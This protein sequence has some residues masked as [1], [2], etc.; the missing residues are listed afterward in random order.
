MLSS[1]GGSGRLLNFDERMKSPSLGLVMGFWGISNVLVIAWWWADISDRFLPGVLR[2]AGIAFFVCAALVP[3]VLLFKVRRSFFNP[4]VLGMLVCCC[5]ALSITAHEA[6][7]LRERLQF[8]LDHER[9]FAHVD[10]VE[11]VIRPL[12]ARITEVYVQVLGDDH[13]R[14][15]STF[16]THIV[17]NYMFDSL[18]F[19]A[20]FAL[21]TLLL[22]PTASW[23]CLLTFAFYTQ[24]AIYP[25]RMGPVFIAG[26]LFWQLFLLVSRRYP[27]AIISGLIISFGRTDVVFAS[28][29]VLLSLAAFERRWPTLKEWGLFGLLVGISIAV[30]KVLIWMHPGTDFRSFL[31][32][33]GDYFSKLVVNLLTMKLAV[34]IA[35]PV[36]AIVIVRTF[37]LTRTMAVVLPAGLI[38]VGIVFVIA[39]FSET[40][41][42]IPALTALAFVASEALG[43]LLETGALDPGVTTARDSSMADG[44]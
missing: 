22:S 7:L 13:T 20:V 43:K 42:I 33:H 14:G 38:H 4:V 37:T 11:G 1:L 19:L 16:H 3:L 18:S 39:D 15:G 41:L 31:I 27:A 30:P 25:G 36:L 44:H 34:A 29:F 35:S 12:I 8:S 32:T 28:A 23:L 40:R 26:G 5:L 9:E 21:A 6:N 10:A 2:Y 17:A 24:I